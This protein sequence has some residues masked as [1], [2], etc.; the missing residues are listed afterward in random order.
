MLERLRLQNFRGFV[1]H[2]VPL[3]ETTVVVGN[4]NAGKSTIVEALRLISVITDRM[5]TDRVRFVDPPA[6]LSGDCAIAG[7]APAVLG[8]P[9]EGMEQALFHAY[10]APPAVLTAT[11]MGGARV[12]ICIGPEAAVHGVAW[13]AQGDEV[14]ERHDV[15]ALAPELVPICAQPQVAPLLRKEVRHLEET[16]VRGDGTYLAPRHFR[17]QLL[18]FGRHTKD[19]CRI[20]EE[21]WPGLQINQLP[22]AQTGHQETL[23]LHVRDGPF[24]GEVGLMGHGLQMWLQIIWFLARAPKN[25]VVVLDEPDVYMHPD[26]QRRLLDLV[27]R[28]FAQLIIA[29]HSVEIISDVAPDSIL[30]VDKTQPASVFVTSLP[31]LQQ[32]M[33]NLGTLQNIQIMRLMRSRSF[34]LVE[35][36]DL[37]LLRILQ[38]VA[39]PA[40]APVDLVPNAELGGRGGWGAGVP[41]QLPTRNA[42]GERIRCYAILDRDYFPDEEVDERVA[43]GKQWNVSLHV[44]ARKEIENYLLV[45]AA[46]C[47]LIT[48]RVD[49]DVEGPDEAAVVAELDQLA[50]AMKDDIVDAMAEVVFALK[51]KAGMTTANKAARSRLAGCWKTEEGRWARLPG[52]KVISALSNWAKEHYG[53]EFNPEQLARSLRRDEVA[54][55]VVAVLEAIAQTRPLKVKP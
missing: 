1:D 39:A 36:E 43:E 42:E 11:F 17:N 46:I 25:A 55:E 48:E 31:G 29:T 8:M 13:N 52:K 19:F 33:S 47:R 20:A 44:W 53:V 3:K 51:K 38:V 41:Q 18:Y 21:T 28:R 9:S 12:A 5:A 40:A 27:R 30:A 14:S 4:N 23:R 15:H 22:E 37:S 26:L 54:P 10:G 35:G 45:P 24:V 32:V 6:W 34:L 50:A 16:I 7:I 49:A 2:E